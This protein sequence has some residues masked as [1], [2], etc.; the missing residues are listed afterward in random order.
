MSGD[1][2]V[3]PFMVFLAAF[4]FGMPVFLLLLN[5]WIEWSQR[6]RKEGDPNVSGILMV[7]GVWAFCG[8]VAMFGWWG[9]CFLLADWATIMFIRD[10]IEREPW[11][12]KPS[13]LTP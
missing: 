5:A 11:L 3:D 7:G 8:G 10:W 12:G 13:D 9:V 2:Q 6:N 4:A 1:Y